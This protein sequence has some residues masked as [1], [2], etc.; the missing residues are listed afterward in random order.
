V[1]ALNAQT[2]PSDTGPEPSPS[3]PRKPAAESRAAAPAPVARREP[4]AR[5]AVVGDVSGLD[6]RKARRFKRGELPVD[7]R[8]DLHGLTVEQAHGALDAFIRRQHGFG[9]RCVMV[10]TGRGDPEKGG[11][12][13]RSEAPAWLN[14]PRLRPL[15]LA[16]T[17]ARPRH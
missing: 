4:S 16:V 10:I 7:A 5:P 17:E 1:R 15:V 12:R 11:G 6:A 8:L 14:H 2:H 3:R 9:A 13:I